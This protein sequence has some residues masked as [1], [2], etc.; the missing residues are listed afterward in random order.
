MSKVMVAVLFL[1]VTAPA[2]VDSSPDA[3]IRIQAETPKQEYLPGEP[4]CVTLTLTNDANAPETIVFPGDD[5]A[6]DITLTDANGLALMRGTGALE[7]LRHGSDKGPVNIPAGGTAR[8]SFVLN[9]RCSTLV[10]PGTVT[11]RCI[12]T[13]YVLGEPS[14]TEAGSVSSQSEHTAKVAIVFEVLA[15]DRAK[16]ER[17]LRDLSEKMQQLETQGAFSGREGLEARIA[18][19][20]T[21]AFAEGDAAVPYQLALLR[22]NS[23]GRMRQMYALGSLERTATPAAAEALMAMVGEPR[24]YG[25]G[26]ID[27]DD[28]IRAVYKMRDRG[29]PEVRK[30]TEKF[31][32]T[33]P[34]PP[35]AT[36]WS[37]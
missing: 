5:E 2:S 6:F 12:V 34:R 1:T 17:I 32:S 4:V 28:L 13:Y 21:L 9:H 10:R 37:L 24:P 11:A 22:D 26:T 8:R 36:R 31:V 27:D 19:I 25:M 3:G 16:Y 29:G 14:I 20:E 35:E 23:I 33:H 30:L 7:P 18:G 15:P